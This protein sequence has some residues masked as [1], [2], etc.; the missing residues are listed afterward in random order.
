MKKKFSLVKI[1][2]QDAK[3]S[4]QLF[5]PRFESDLETSRKFKV[6]QVVIGSVTKSEIRKYELLK[7][8]FALIKL[9]LHNLPEEL[10]GHIKSVDELRKIVIME[11]GF[12]EEHVSLSGKKF[13]SAESIAFDKMS[14][15]RFSDLYSK[16]FDVVCEKILPGVTKKDVEEQIMGFL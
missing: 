11:A 7:K 15:E 8:F 4:S 16:A 6:G 9:A 5:V 2:L 14:E 12:R 10:S 13:W 3:N 1:S